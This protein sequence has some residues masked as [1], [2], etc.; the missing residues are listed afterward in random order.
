MGGTLKRSL[1]DI[2][3]HFDYCLIDCPP[4][5]GILVVNALVAGS[6]LIVPLQTE[7]M[8]IASIDRLLNT[9]AMI[10]RARGLSVPYTIVPTM[11]DRRTRAS[12]ESLARLRERQDIRLWHEVIPVDTQLREASRIGTPLTCWQPRAKGSVAYE[13][14]VEQLLMLD[15]T[16]GLRQAG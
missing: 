12:R 5:L 7:F 9:L 4:M 13:R 8:A 2:A 11:F 10:Q 16:T 1:Q 6:S 15:E 3:V 14:L